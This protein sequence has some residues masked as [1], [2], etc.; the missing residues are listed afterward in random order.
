MTSQRRTSILLSRF[1]SQGI[2]AVNA[3]HP[4]KATTMTSTSS[5]QSTIDQLNRRTM[6]DAVGVYARFDS[7]GPAEVAALQ[8]VA[9]RVRNGRILDIGVGGGRTVG[10]L[11]ELSRDYIGVDY[12]N[13]MVEA[14][15]TRFPNVRFEHADAR[16]MPQFTDASF[17]LIV[18]AWAG[19]CMVDHEG[20]IAILNEV[21]RL[22]K[23]GGAFVFSSYN[24]NSA[25][26]T[27]FFSLPE[28]AWSRSPLRLAKNALTFT[29]ALA[30]R[31]INRMR[32]L[33]KEIRTNEFGI[34]NDVSHDY[35]TLLYYISPRN[36]MQQLREAGFVNEV[37]TYD[38]SGGHADQ[39]CR[40]GSITYVA[41]G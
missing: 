1:Q 6:R 34:I 37:S 15:R 2:R 3:P 41:I 23:P 35:S 22:L 28:F 8:S 31:I 38:G 12:V 26:Y 11:L 14:C 9:D 33:P 39:N 10:A 20:R 13:E 25:D 24:Q 40:D 17:D 16:A 19:I 4:N 5:G 7:L 30:R 36:Q 29:H 18:F 32:F 21:R 27:R